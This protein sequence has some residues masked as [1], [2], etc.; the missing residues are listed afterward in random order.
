MVEGSTGTVVDG[1]RVDEIAAAV[2]DL[3]ADPDRA[4]KMG[5][6]GR[7]WVLTNWRW[8]VLA[9]RLGG[10]LAAEPPRQSLR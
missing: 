5:A 4:A 1:R 6:A 10:L 3:L 9:A 8:D 7:D 2:G